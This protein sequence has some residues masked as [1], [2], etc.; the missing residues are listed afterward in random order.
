LDSSE[1]SDSRYVS[2]NI[3]FVYL[4]WIWLLNSILIDIN[5]ESETLLFQSLQSLKNFSL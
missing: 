2:K 3:Y 5:T 1:S 4:F